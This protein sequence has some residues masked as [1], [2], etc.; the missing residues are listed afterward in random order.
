MFILQRQFEFVV[1][2]F[3]DRLRRR[4]DNILS[5]EVHRR[6]DDGAT[7]VQQRLL[8]CFLD[9]IL[10]D[11]SPLIGRRRKGYDDMIDVFGKF[12]GRLKTQK[13]VR[14]DPCNLWLS[15]KRQ[16]SARPH[17]KKVW[18]SRHARSVPFKGERFLCPQLSTGPD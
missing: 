18:S 15:D 14:S 1:K 9:S 5:K 16:A 6:I 3:S 8:R 4:T 12:G 7:E 2:T 17:A 10:R 13:E 11:G